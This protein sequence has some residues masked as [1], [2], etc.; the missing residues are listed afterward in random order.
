M[1]GCVCALTPISAEMREEVVTDG[2][3]RDMGVK[4]RVWDEGAELARR[5]AKLQ[6]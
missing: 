2:D 1:G 4:T 3:R 6:K 5:R